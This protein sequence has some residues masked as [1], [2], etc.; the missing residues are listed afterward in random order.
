MIKKPLNTLSVKTIIEKL[1]KGEIIYCGS[2][3]FVQYKMVDGYICR[4]EKDNCTDIGTNL[5]ISKQYYFEEE[6]PI[7]FEVGKHYKTKANTE[8]VCFMFRVDYN[9]NEFPIKLIE[10][11][12]EKIMNTDKNEKFYEPN[13]DSSNNIVEWS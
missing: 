9:D 12:S 2:N 6:E 4:Y 7:K 5:V 11:N 1:Q 13:S 3:S 8:L 10:L